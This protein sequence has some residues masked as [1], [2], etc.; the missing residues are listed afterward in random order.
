MNLVN[1]FPFHF[2]K[3]ISK[4]TKKG[5]CQNKGIYLRYAINFALKHLHLISKQRTQTNENSTQVAT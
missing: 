1:T 4:I 3:Q 5:N 2:L